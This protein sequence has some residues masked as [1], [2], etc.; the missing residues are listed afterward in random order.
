MSLVGTLAR[1]AVAVGAAKGIGHVMGRATQSAATGGT[2]AQSGN[3]QAGRGLGT[4]FE[5]LGAAPDIGDSDSGTGGS[6]HA[7]GRDART[8]GFSQTRATNNEGQRE[9]P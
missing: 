3:G 2:D 7:E 8:G 6:T 4:L 1:V 9:G 5:Q